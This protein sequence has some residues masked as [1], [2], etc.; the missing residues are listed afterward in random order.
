MRVQA[1]VRVRRELRLREVNWPLP[2]HPVGR[3]E[4]T[5]WGS[6]ALMLPVELPVGL[7][8]DEFIVKDGAEMAANR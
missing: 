8:V 6:A 7:R 2:S 4:A 3:R 5:G 1:E